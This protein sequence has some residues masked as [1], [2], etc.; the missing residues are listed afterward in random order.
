MAKVK[1]LGNAACVTSAAKLA[2]IQMLEKYRKDALAVYGGDD[3]KTQIFRVTTGTG[4]GSLDELCAVFCNHTND[5][6]G[7]A[8]ITVHLCGACENMKEGL[9]D[10]FGAGLINLAKVEQAIPAAIEAVKAERDSIMAQI[11]LA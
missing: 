8:Q 10:I 1:V 4:D 11:E 5:P 7:F 9:A 6:D 2:D 3:G